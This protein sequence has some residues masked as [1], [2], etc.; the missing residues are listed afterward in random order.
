MGS[1]P[2]IITH[3]SRIQ[4]SDCFIE[5]LCSLYINQG[6]QQTRTEGIKLGQPLVM[7]SKQLS[8]VVM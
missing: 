3:G 4:A 7:K 6:D 2:G 1:P 8:A 5:Q